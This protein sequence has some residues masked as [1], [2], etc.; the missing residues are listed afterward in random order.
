MFDANSITRRLRISGISADLLATEPTARGR[1][2]I[3]CQNLR[4]PATQEGLICLISYPSNDGMGWK[5]YSGFHNCVYEHCEGI[6][7]KK[8]KKSSTKR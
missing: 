1:N 2:R 7:G 5:P 8:K 6:F 4:G 3:T